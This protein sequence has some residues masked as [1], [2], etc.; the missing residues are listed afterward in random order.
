[1][2]RKIESIPTQS[3][4]SIDP[5]EQGITIDYS[6]YE[7]YLEN[8]DLSEDQ[9]KEFLDT[10]WQMVTAFVDMGFGVHPIQQAKEA[11]AVDSP[12]GLESKFNLAGSRSNSPNEKG[13][14]NDR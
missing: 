8:S 5:S 4:Q 14:A 2:K 11:T 6:L 7:H 9:K 1:V 13:I 12:T 3:I 10:L